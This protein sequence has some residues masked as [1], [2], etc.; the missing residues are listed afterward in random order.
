MKEK[1][2]EKR[3]KKKTVHRLVVLTWNTRACSVNHNTQRDWSLD[4]S[5][6]D[7]IL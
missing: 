5:L 6:L 3:K 2:K 4:V 7:L 1:E